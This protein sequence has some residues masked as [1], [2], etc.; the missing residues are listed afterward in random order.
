MLYGRPASSTTRSSWARSGGSSGL[1]AAAIRRLGRVV[2]QVQVLIVAHIPVN[3]LVKKTSPKKYYVQ[4]N[5]GI[6]APR[7][8]VVVLVKLTDC[9]SQSG[10]VPCS[11]CRGKPGHITE[12][13]QRRHVHQRIGQHGERG[14]AEG[15]LRS[16]VATDIHK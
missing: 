7:S 1:P 4:P 10:R 15:C 14:E 6:V 3:T 16:T 5:N 13:H 8:T 11:E 2:R 12:G 9:I